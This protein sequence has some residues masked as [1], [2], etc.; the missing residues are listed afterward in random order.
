MYAN[1]TQIIMKFTREIVAFA[2]LFIVAQP[3]SAQEQNKPIVKTDNISDTISSDS[4]Q[5][6]KA[7]TDTLSLTPKRPNIFRRIINY[8]S[9]TNVD[10]TFVK[11]IDWSIAPGPNYSSDI[12][13]GFGVMI[14]GLYR[15]DR[16]DSVTQP[17][18]LTFYGNVTTKKFVLARCAGQNVFAKNKYRISYAAAIVH[19]PGAFYGV[20]YDDGEQGYA[21]SLTTTMYIARISAERKMFKNMYIGISAGLDYTGAKPQ[22]GISRTDVNKMI[23]HKDDLPGE[24]RKLIDGYLAGNII[25]EYTTP[26]Q[27]Y[28]NGIEGA[29]YDVGGKQQVVK[30][31]EGT[32]EPYNALNTN[33]GVCLSYDSRD[34]GPNAQKGIYAKLEAKCY[35]KFLGNSLNTFGK[36][37]FQFDAYQRL[38]KGSVLGFDLFS[39]FTL[40]TPSWHLYSKL[41]GTDH[42]RGYY[43]GRYRDSKVVEAQVELRQKIYRRHGIVGW[44]GYGTVWGQD[45]FQ[46]GHVVPSFGC[47]YRFEFKHRMNIRLDYGWG[48]FGNKNLFWDN[49][50]SSAFLFTASESF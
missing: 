39:D 49:K 2:L 20:G 47:G 6:S 13:F 50:R 1:Q 48:R 27:N 42:M 33:V 17:S 41:G 34:F 23:D 9:K 5:T 30:S 12:G 8:Y 16:K 38:W 40:G 19:F 45:K 26:F 7:D 36:I 35:P 25:P 28:I 21:Q 4:L 15:L 11:K 46:W 3:L 29:T 18:H 24:Q 31:K 22:Q 43:E 10:R 44:I 14:A 37:V 32:H